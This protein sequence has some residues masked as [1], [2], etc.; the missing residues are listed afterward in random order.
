MPEAPVRMIKSCLDTEVSAA[1][2]IRRCKGTRSRRVA[3]LVR[4]LP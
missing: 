1:G 4:A 2:A 3:Q